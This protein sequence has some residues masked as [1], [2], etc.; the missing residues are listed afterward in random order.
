MDIARARET[1]KSLFRAR[2]F[3]RLDAVGDT[4]LL[5]QAP[6]KRNVR[7]IFCVDEPKLGIKPLRELQDHFDDS[8]E[9]IMI[10]FRG[11]ITSFAKAHLS[12]ISSERVETFELGQLQFD[13]TKHALVPEHKEISV[14]AARRLGLKADLVCKLLKTDPIARWYKWLPNTFVRITRTSPEGHSYHEYRVVK[15]A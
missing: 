15:A 6:G 4:Q 10:V 2:G 5:A 11:A 9:D 7:V 12:K 13:I 8:S 3:T 1:L 14:R